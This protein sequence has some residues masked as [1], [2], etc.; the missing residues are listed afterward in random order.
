MLPCGL[1]NCSGR[2]PI[3]AEREV[4]CDLGGTIDWNQ[5]E[6]RICL[7]SHVLRGLS[8]QIRV[9]NSNTASKPFPVVMLSQ[10]FQSIE[11]TIRGIRQGTIRSFIAWNARLSRAFAFG[12]R[13]NASKNTCRSRS[14]STIASCRV[15]VARVA[16]ANAVRQKSVKLRRSSAAARSTNLLVCASTRKPRREP[17]ARRFSP[18][19][20]REACGIAFLVHIV[21]P[22]GVH[23]QAGVS[24]YRNSSPANSAR[25]LRQTIQVCMPGVSMSTC[26]TPFCFSHSRK[27]RFTLIRR[28]SV[29]QA[30]QSRRTC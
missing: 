27:S 12:G 14:E 23:F 5:D 20:I 24:R 22:M 17:R 19:A 9:E 8:F 4:P 15:I 29:P 3:S 30:I 26:C 18:F 28:S 25:F 16:S 6:N 10:W 7:A 11:W 21:R 1:W 2:K 13:T